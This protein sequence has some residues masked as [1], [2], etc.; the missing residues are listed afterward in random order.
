MPQQFRI[1]IPLLILVLA[2]VACT[3][4]EGITSDADLDL[5]DEDDSESEPVEQSDEEDEE[6][7]DY[8]AIEDGDLPLLGE[9]AIATEVTEYVSGL[10]FITD[11]VWA[12]D[13]RL[14]I[15]E[16][17][18]NVRVVSADGEL[19]EDPVIF[20][21]SHQEGERGLLGLAIDPT[22]EDTGYIWAYH[23]YDQPDSD[24]P[25]HRI[26]RFTERRGQ[27]SDME[28]AFTAREV[29]LESTILYGGAL[30]F[31]PDGMLYFD[32]GSGNNIFVVRDMEQPHGKI[33]R[34]TPTVPVGIP[35]DNPDPNS[36]IYATG[37]R[38]NFKLTFHPE[39]GIPYAAMNGPDCD[40]EINRVLPGGHYGWRIDGL[41]E[42]NNLPHE[43]ATDL[44][45]EFVAPVLSFTPTVSPTGIMFYT[46]DQFP[47]WENHMF[48]CFYNLG[49]INR[50]ELAEDGHGVLGAEVIGSGSK[51]CTTTILD[52]PDGNIYF[53]D[54]STVNILGR[55]GTE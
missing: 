25:Q 55:V 29:F 4:T 42:N 20:L 30:E 50:V 16:K 53:A 37:F 13:G 19:Q 12:P 14:F 1:T 44:S 28:I 36:T 43:Y 10:A 35:E 2:L 33:H 8:D 7:I 31:G 48:F 27:G 52:G 18:G 17:G 26:V 24:E 11:M 15:A 45:G 9:A 21:E 3:T 22:F 5:P 34:F 32:P 38:N 41:C 39:T 46:G 47:E 6:L 49:S 54:I 23:I 51:N 40:D